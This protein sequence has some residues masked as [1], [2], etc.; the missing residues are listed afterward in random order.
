MNWLV[1][2]G[3]RTTPFSHSGAQTPWSDFY[4]KYVILKIMLLQIFDHW[5]TKAVF[6]GRGV[7]QRKSLVDVHVNC[8]QWNSDDDKHHNWQE[9]DM[10]L[11]TTGSIQT[12]IRFIAQAQFTNNGHRVACP[13]KWQ[14]LVTFPV[15][16]FKQPMEETRALGEF[17]IQFSNSVIQL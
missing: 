6:S 14:Q 12:F 1:S 2:T 3:S 16:R 11:Q 15:I 17:F 13:T 10:T 9:H 7:I 8:A 4:A 5:P